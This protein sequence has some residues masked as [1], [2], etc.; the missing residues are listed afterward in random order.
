VTRCHYCNQ[1]VD[2]AAK[3]VLQAVWGWEHRAETRH[4]GTKGGSDIRY[5][6]PFSRYAHALCVE[7]ERT[8]LSA[9]QESLV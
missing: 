9:R 2:P 3:T 7:R 1:P 8:G 6:Q 5:R 4:T